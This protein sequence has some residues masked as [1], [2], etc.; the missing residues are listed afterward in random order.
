MR[1]PGLQS[2]LPAALLSLTLT[3]LAP[4]AQAELF[5]V[6]AF[7]DS[8]KMYHETTG[9][10][11]GNFV[12]NTDVEP[13]R[14]LQFPRQAAFDNLGRL[15]VTGFDNFALRHYSPIGGIL[16]T[17]ASASTSPFFGQPSG[18]VIRS[19]FLFVGDTTL[20]DVKRYDLSKP[21]AE[22]FVSVFASG[23]GL[24][25]PDALAF[26]PDGHLYVADSNQ[27]L[28]F[29]GTTG[30]FLGALPNGAGGLSQARDL[31]FGADGFLYVADPSV[32]GRVLRYSTASGF[33]GFFAVDANLGSPRSLAFGPAG[34]LYV[35]DEADSEVRRYTAAGA[36]DGVLVTTAGNGGLSS[37]SDLVFASPLTPAAKV[38]IPAHWWGVLGMVMVFGSIYSRR[39]RHPAA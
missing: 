22:A 36:P 3:V 26:G 31:A 39:R 14:R 17:F 20:G 15:F 33:A 18:V 13:A 25:N 11:L 12:D 23:N 4:S 34:K 28:R 16:G 1:V 21:A 30:A 2:F 19:G 8:I 9:V 38:E 6:D 35:G 29:H 7:N 27:I 32:S 10:F 37:P 24:D 5:V